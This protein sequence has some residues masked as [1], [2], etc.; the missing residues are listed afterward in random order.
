MAGIA[1]ACLVGQR[2]LCSWRFGDLNSRG[3]NLKTPPRQGRQD[4]VLN[5]GPFLGIGTPPCTP[6]SAQRYCWHRRADPS[7][8]AHL[9]HLLTTLQML[10]GRDDLHFRM[11]LPGRRLSSS[12]EIPEDLQP[13]ITAVLLAS[14]L[15][16]GSP[17]R[18]YNNW[19]Q[20]IRG[21]QK[22]LAADHPA[23]YLEMH[24][25]TEDKKHRKAR[26]IIEFLST[27]GYRRIRGIET[28]TTVTMA[29]SAVANQGH[30]YCTVVAD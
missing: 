27:A 26:E 3:T 2:I 11:S 30:I 21:M 28:G 19:G 15:C 25:A 5:F 14:V 4:S 23:L 22:T 20:V 6:F 24:G 17:R 8:P 13:K 16:L 18:S 29:N 7:L 12:L 9:R 10:Q 1:Q